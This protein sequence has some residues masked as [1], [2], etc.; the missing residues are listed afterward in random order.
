[1][2][3]TSTT[4]TRIL[5]A[6]ERLFAERGFDR[7]SLRAITSTAGV[8]LAAVNYHFRSKHDLIRAVFER[9]IGP[10]NARRIEL[11]D[12]FEA[13]AHGRP[14]PVEKVI[15]A[16]I[17]P[18]LR[19]PGAQDRT[20]LPRLVGRLYSD[21]NPAV[22]EIFIG[23][24]GDIARRFSIAMQR[25]LP[26]V[27]PRDLFWRMGFAIGATVITMAAAW[28]I[29]MLSRGLCDPSDIEG[30]QERLIAFVVA[31]LRSPLPAQV[32]P[33]R[34][35]SVPSCVKNSERGR[36]QGRGRPATAEIA[37]GTVVR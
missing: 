31:G 21:P 16:L 30:T 35:R 3:S 28:I 33:P 17:E 19:L 14:V 34:A 32:D 27:P 20:S 22:R 2:P 6:A 11:L 25:A 10:L 7:A 12:A 1:M 15:R 29:E 24:F 23:E 37:P 36:R 13:E 8:N 5:E 18:M 26:Q 4:K 9:H